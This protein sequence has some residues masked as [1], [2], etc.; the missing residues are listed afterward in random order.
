VGFEHLDR[1]VVYARR[2][3]VRF[4]KTGSKVR[5]RVHLIYQAEPFASLHPLFQGCQHPFRPDA[6]FNPVPSGPDLSSLRSRFRHSRWFVFRRSFRHVST[7]LRSLGSIPITG[8]RRYYGRSDSRPVGSSVP[9]RQREHL[10]CSE[11]VSLLYAPELPIPLSPTTHHP[12]DIALA[13]YPSA[14]RVSRLLGSRL[15]HCSAGSPGLAGR[16]EFV[17]LRMDRSPP[18]ALHPASQR[19]S[20][21]RLQAG[22]RMPGGDLHP[23]VQYYK[24]SCACR[25]TQRARL[26]RKTWFFAPHCA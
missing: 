16:I 17:I 19:R 24:T 1:L 2:P 3:S 22:E 7:S 8:F 13:R 18:A 25:R 15:R 12:L 11:R 20:C 26:A 5:Q 21:S 6:R 9:Y 10:L 14:C 23:S 4:C